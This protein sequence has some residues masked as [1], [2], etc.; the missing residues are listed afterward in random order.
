M[1]EGE[2]MKDKDPRISCVLSDD[3]LIDKLDNQ[4]REMCVTR[5]VPLM[6]IPARPNKDFDL[7]LAEL[8]V[9]YMKLTENN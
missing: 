9:R 7:L 1:L 8:M 6:S 5:K 2:R 3:E 4:L